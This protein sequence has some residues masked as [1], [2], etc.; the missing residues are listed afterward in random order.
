MHERANLIGVQRTEVNPTE[1]D[2]VGEVVAEFAVGGSEVG[3]K[4][5]S[6]VARA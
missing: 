2:I 1:K 3:N 6:E 4:F 5:R